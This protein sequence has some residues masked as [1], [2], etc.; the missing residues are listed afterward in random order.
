MLIDEVWRDE[1]TEKNTVQRTV[2]SL[3]TML[4]EA[5]MGDLVIDG[6]NKDHYALILP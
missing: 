6:D 1:E 2:S 5:G 3:R 4:R